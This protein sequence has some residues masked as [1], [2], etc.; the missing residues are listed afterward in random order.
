MLQDAV[1][2]SA[3]SQVRPRGGSAHMGGNAVVQHKLAFR[4]RRAVLRAAH[5]AGVRTGARL[6]G[7]LQHQVIVCQIFA[8][9]EAG[10]HQPV[11]LPGHGPGGSKHHPPG[12]RLQL[13]GEQ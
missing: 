6:T 11:P 8:I 5:H 13:G 7:H 4:L 1:W 3:I 12:V 2:P 9:K 10:G